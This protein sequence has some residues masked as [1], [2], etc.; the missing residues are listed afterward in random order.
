MMDFLL[1]PV[2]QAVIWTAVFVVLIVIGIYIVKRFRDQIDED[3]PGP[4]EHISFFREIYDEGDITE[5]E[6]RTIKTVLSEQ[7][8]GTLSD[9]DEES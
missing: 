3:M 7:L 8:E 9:P 1:Q 6:F 4:N 2:P 5:T